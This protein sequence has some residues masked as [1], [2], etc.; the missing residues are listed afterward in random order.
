MARKKGQSD[1]E[2]IYE[3]ALNQL[4]MI[5]EYEKRLAAAQ[6]YKDRQKIA[7]GIIG[8]YCIALHEFDRLLKMPEH[9]ELKEEIKKRRDDTYKK[10]EAVPERYKDYLVRK[11]PKK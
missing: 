9:E 10:W 6:T 4:G 11:A 8:T 7:D 5:K 3:V 1:F 2:L